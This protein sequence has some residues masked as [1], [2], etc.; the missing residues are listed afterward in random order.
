VQQD[1]EQFQNTWLNRREVD[2]A[3]SELPTSVPVSSVRTMWTSLYICSLAVALVCTVGMF[4]RRTVR[5]CVRPGAC[6]VRGGSGRRVDFESSSSSDRKQL[7]VG[8]STFR[9]SRRR[10]LP[11]VTS[12]YRRWII[13]SPPPARGAKYCDERVWTSVCLSARVSKTR[14]L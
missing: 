5:C 7:R 3:C 2:E 8:C 11:Y 4:Q 1:H 6:Q 12:V 10:P 9:A 13:T 14:H